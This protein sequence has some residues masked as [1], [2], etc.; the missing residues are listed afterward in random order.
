MENTVIR[1]DQ[2]DYYD[3]YWFPTTLYLGKKSVMDYLV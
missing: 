1:K 3:Y 2:D